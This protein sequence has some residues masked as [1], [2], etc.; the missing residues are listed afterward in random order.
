MYSS[1]FEYYFRVGGAASCPKSAEAEMM[2]T[3]LNAIDLKE[4]AHTVPTA[5]VTAVSSIDERSFPSLYLTCAEEP[6]RIY[7]AARP[8]LVCSLELA[9]TEDH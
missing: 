9:K 3:A 2:I 1:H 4:D 6:V 8:E 5:Y 7:G